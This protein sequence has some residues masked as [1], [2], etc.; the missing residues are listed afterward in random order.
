MPEPPPDAIAR[1]T[2]WLRDVAVDRSERVVPVPGGAV[3]LHSRYAGAHDH[4]RLLVWSEV[5]GAAAEAAVEDLLGAAGLS[6]RRID[7]LSA[8]LADRMEPALSA[9]GYARSDEIVMRLDHRPAARPASGPVVELDLDRRASAAEA[10]WRDEQP[11][12]RPEV[13][14]Q[15]GERIRATAGVLD[16]TF[17]AVVEGDRVLAR[18]DL[19]M[20]AGVAQVEEV[21][22]EPAGRNQGFGSALVSE[23]V[24]RADAAGADL[25][26][27]VA[28]ADD[29]PAQWYTRLG[30]VELFATASF[31]R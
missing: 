14:H 30:F 20:R 13:S 12:W 25:T 10:S 4:N 3:L 7:V 16:A 1:I 11:D 24:S 5:D 6:H 17:L 22:T 23:A 15:L 26:F 9:A 18:T 21:M 8:E 28:D 19:L 27:L 31:S 29:W 2:D